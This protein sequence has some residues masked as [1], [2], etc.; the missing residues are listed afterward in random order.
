[1]SA[2]SQRPFQLGPLEA[3]YPPPLEAWGPPDDPGL[4][5]QAAF[6]VE[7]GLEAIDGEGD[8]TGKDGG[9]TVDDG[10]DDGV[11]LAVV[12]GLVVAGEGDEA[13]E[14]Q[15]ERE[16]DLGGCVDPGLRVGQLL[17]L[18]SQQGQDWRTPGGNP[19]LPDQQGA[20]G[21]E[22]G[23][24]LPMAH[25]QP[26]AGLGP[27]PSSPGPTRAQPGPQQ[28]KRILLSYPPLPLTCRRCAIEKCKIK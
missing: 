23:R 5:V 19:R 1:M 14:P 25:S 18:E 2:S 7:G 21:P 15:A 3:H 12:G 24:K 17:H 9:G 22:R 16:E 6:V 20:G 27:E 10:H 28:I 11:L 8:D 4:L 13:A 26:D